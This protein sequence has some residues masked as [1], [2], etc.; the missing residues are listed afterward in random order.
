LPTEI[1]YP[2]D[3]QKKCD[4]SKKICLNNVFGKKRSNKKEYE[5]DQNQIKFNC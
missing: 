2:Y 3:K 4:R 1:S 5:Y